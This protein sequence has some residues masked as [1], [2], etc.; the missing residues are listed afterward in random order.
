MIETPKSME[1]NKN[2]TSSPK[3]I[4]QYNKVVG[5]LT[6]IVELE[7]LDFGPESFEVLRD[8][9]KNAY[10]SNFKLTLFNRT[11]EES[12]RRPA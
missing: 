8:S 11:A 7:R 3:L 1:K 12:F 2:M 6:K 5:T 4:N 10:S 9:L